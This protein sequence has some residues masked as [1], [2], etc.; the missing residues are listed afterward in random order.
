MNKTLIGLLVL[1]LVIS[2]CTTPPPS[3]GTPATPTLVRGDLTWEQSLLV[4]QLAQK[5]GVSVNVIMV[6]E[7]TAVTWPDQCL[8]TVQKD[9]ACAQSEVPGYR[10]VLFV[11]G[12]N[13]EYHTNLDMS[14]I[15][16]VENP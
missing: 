12:T 15:L 11:N 5:L 1:L 9:L 10:F 7:T 8:G 13:Y 4:A 2:G 6:A 14:V 3:A 16:P